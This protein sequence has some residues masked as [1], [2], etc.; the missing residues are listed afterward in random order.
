MLTMCI[1]YKTKYNVTTQKPEPLS[2]RTTINSS[3]PLYIVIKIN[4]KKNGN[5]TLETKTIISR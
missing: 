4:D 2:A 1:Q 5:Q 3:D